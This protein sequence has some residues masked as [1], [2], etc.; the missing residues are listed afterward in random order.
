[1]KTISLRYILL[2]LTCVWMLDTYGQDHF[3]EHL[4][5]ISQMTPHKAIY[6][7]EQYQLDFP[8]YPAV[9]Y[10]LGRL[11]ESQIASIH[12]IL[13]YS[14]LRRSLYNTKLFYGNFRHFAKDVSLKAD[15]Y[16]GIRSKRKHMEYSDVASF[17]NE[18]L[19]RVNE[20]Q[21][22][23]VELYTSYDRMVA[24]YE[25]CRR[26]FTKFC[27][28]YP[29]EKQAHLRLQADDV[30]LMHTLAQQFDSLKHDI[31]E[32][33][34]ALSEYPIAGYSPVFT[35]T[36]IRLYRLDGL[37]RSNF[38][39][40]SI[41]L[42]NYGAFAEEFLH[43]QNHD[44][45][46]Y[47]QAIIKEYQQIDKA[48]YEVR[49]G[50]KQLVKTNK[51]LPNYI[52]KMDYESF[53][54]PLTH[55]QQVCGDMIHC[56]GKGLFA[57]DSVVDADQIELALH[58]LYDRYVSKDKCYGMKDTLSAKLTEQEL[59]KYTMV[60]GSATTS[61]L[62]KLAEDR[63]V[64]ADSMYV[65]LSKRF[66]EKIEGTL[67][68]FEKYTDE[69]KDLVIYAHQ[70]P[71]LGSKVAAVLSVSTGYLVVYEDGILALLN[72][73]LELVR[74]LEYPSYAPIKTAYKIGG[75][76]VAI[77]SPECIYWVGDM[78]IR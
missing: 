3:D 65:E 5:A 20:V 42:W 76:N 62:V 7:L 47:Y 38:M 2:A 68:E 49:N 30:T 45:A 4:L 37:T 56:Y 16:E 48:V 8:K 46:K 75:N 70:I 50:Q 1:M 78:A 13:N 27:E 21:T 57:N 39:E 64:V 17:V 10:H 69:L 26:M 24:R 40:S 43:K 58:T 63:L 53:M 74:K 28:Q 51:I 15:H 60:F 19:K 55:I 35:Y 12:P 71:Q 59:Q 14:Y 77:V 29:G 73:Q 33:E 41:S 22:R 6:H 67:G 44:Y 61:D 32:F 18:K 54:V 72:D 23:V 9:Y 11:S 31:Q 25:E 34:A 52:N 66:Y 36:D